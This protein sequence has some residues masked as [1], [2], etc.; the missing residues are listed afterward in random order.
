MT[1]VCSLL[2]LFINV[3]FILSPLLRV[4]V[5]VSAMPLLE[6]LSRSSIAVAL[7]AIERHAVCLKI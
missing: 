6:L 3:P 1:V 4:K 5:T 2:S 7:Q